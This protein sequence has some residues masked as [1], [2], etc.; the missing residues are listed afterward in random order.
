MRN[1]ILKKWMLLVVFLFFG[2]G[3][4][5]QQTYDL[6]AENQSVINEPVKPLS[7]VLSSDGT[8]NK[9]AKITG[10]FNASGYTMSYAPNGAPVFAK[11][12]GGGKGPGDENW[13]NEFTGFL[14]PLETLPPHNPTLIYA[15]A[16]D[17]SGN[18]YIGGTF[19]SIQY[20][21]SA[22]NIAK[23]NGSTWS[24]LGT[25]VQSIFGF[26]VHVYALAIDGSGNLYAGGDFNSAGGVD[27][28]NIAKWNGSAWS[29]LG[30]GTNS[31]VKAIKIRGSNVYVGG[32]FSQA[33]GIP[34][35]Q[36]IAKWDGSDW[37]AIGT[38]TN[39]WVNAIAFDNSGNI[40]IGGEFTQVNN[41]DA[42]NIAKWN[43]STS[44]WNPLINGVDNEV[45][46]LTIDGSGCV[47]VGGKFINVNVNSGNEV[48]ANYIAKWNPDLSQW[49][50]LG[51]GVSHPV[52]ALAFDS[53]SGNIYVGGDLAFL[54]GQYFAAWNGS[55]WITNCPG[56]DAAVRAI[57]IGS[58]GD[59]YVGA[60]FH[61]VVGGDGSLISQLRLNCIAKW[62]GSVWSALGQ[63][64]ND[65]VNAI[66]IDGSGNVYVGGKFRMV[67]GIYVN[68]IAKWDGSAWSAL[69]TGV[70]G[71]VSAIATDG[72]GNVYAG[73]SFT[74][75]GGVPDTPGFA[76]WDGSAW[77]ALT[78][79]GQVLMNGSEIFAIAIR[80]SN[81][82]IGGRFEMVIEEFISTQ[83]IAKWDGTA[84]SALGSGM[85]NGFS[86]Y[87]IDINANGNVY[88]GGNFLNAGGV[89]ANK[90]A[91]WNGTAWSALGTGMN[92]DVYAIVCDAAGNV[93]AGGSFSDAG[94]VYVGGIAKWNGSAW[95]RV[96]T[97]GDVFETRSLAIDGSGNLYVGGVWAYINWVDVNKV[98]KWN[99]SVWSNIGSGTDDQVF[100]LKTYDNSI[101]FG[102]DFKSAGGK[103][104]A[105]F[106]KYTTSAPEIN[107]KQGTTAIADGTGTYGFGNVNLGG[108]SGNITF[109]IENLGTSVLNLTGTP[110]V[111]LS[112]A[113]AGDFSIVQTSTTSTVA[114]SGSTTF[115]ISFAPTASGN[116]T[117]TISIAN[118]DINENPYNFTITGTGTAPEID[119]K[120][121]ST[122]I[123]D[124]TGSYDFGIQ[125]VSTNTD[126]IFTIE[127]TGTGASSLSSFS[128]TGTNANQFSFQGTNPTTVSASGTTTFT[129]RFTPTST[130][131][132]SATISFA[133]EDSDENPYNFTLNGTGTGIFIWDGSESS[134]WNTSGNWNLNA[135]PTA[136]DDVIIANAGIAPVI[137]PS[138]EASCKALS[139][140]TGA[141]LNINSDAS[142]LTYG[143]I[144]N[145]GTINVKRDI[146]EESWHLVSIPTVTANANVFLGDYLQGYDESYSLWS[147]IIPAVTPLAPVYGYALWATYTPGKGFADGGTDFSY[148]FTGTPNTGGQS[149]AFTAVNDYGWNLMGN[150]Y[151]SYL[152]WD[153]VIASQTNMNG[154]VYFYDGS[155]Y[156]SYNNGIGGGSRYIAPMQGFFISATANG[157]FN[158]TNSHRTHTSGTFLKE[159]EIPDH[160]LRLTTTG[161]NITDELHIRLNA[162]ATPDFD[163]QYDAWKLLSWNE[164]APQL[165]SFTGSDMLS[166]DQRP[167]CEMIQLGFSAAIA[168]VYSFAV[169]EM[170][171]FSTVTLEDTKTNTFRNM[172][173]GPYEFVW[174]ATDSETRFKL[175]LNVVGI[176]ETPNSGNNI[177]IYAANNQI[178]IKGAE[179]GEVMVSDVMGRV[180]IKEEIAGTG[181]I[182]VPVN[183]QTGV[184]LVMVKNNGDVKT[185][186]I[187]IR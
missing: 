68:H 52:L 185:E 118:N 149:L 70:N 110:I 54:G 94:G 178:F 129:V 183:L 132:K 4:M 107:V 162:I 184:Y 27:V 147:E 1:F 187:Y 85:E 136:Y 74:E 18:V 181:L 86:V 104:S 95:A 152:D 79:P 182:S 101:Y 56:A 71:Y 48:N 180:I 109:T 98:A 46:A 170:I 66:A 47:Y 64:L 171:D 57:A 78:S 11:A 67:G 29:A 53:Y 76:K 69:G 161:N 63:G 24:A 113:N 80:G 155:T 160:Y 156:V 157:T 139:V 174:D 146:S 77:S 22:N 25:G 141:S 35:T 34:D 126:I 36:G 92:N 150:P 26:D 89:S 173:N 125:T 135:V 97:D 21:V 31:H 6:V 154:G 106:A 172:Q 127:N 90:I 108:N 28:Q 3:A 75:A 105:N 111:E 140:N 43:S 23:W 41:V 145:S 40:F 58:S 148:T 87:A 82:Y 159:K 13:S 133:N 61:V 134:A 30:T 153:A 131:A 14:G 72:S 119:S 59:V 112:G 120:Q 19:S 166:I 176:E 138:V 60:N 91:K 49:S 128:I 100:A 121:G 102:G 83:G 163:G 51:T 7:Q 179:N 164:Q 123:A 175:H 9:K 186:K 165:Y 15:V 84:W 32:G 169:N 5:A 117:A 116:R 99:G 137:T 17:A 81:I 62:N 114:T 10:S 96:G 93:Y 103:N 151:P 42:K 177:L 16:V 143:S 122:S 130:G 115:T 168:G 39:G 8:I 20:G 158:L 2:W 38:G 124:G 44:E 55:D 142:L 65:G 37:S 88:A 144:A 167:A 45:L 73:G 33:G 50:A 12:K